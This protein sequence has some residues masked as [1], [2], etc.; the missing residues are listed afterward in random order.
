MVRGHRWQ[1]LSV[2]AA[3][4]ALAGCTGR[5]AAPAGSDAAAPAA[6]GSQAGSQPAPASAEPITVR[7]GHNRAWSNPALILGLAQDRFKQAGINVV[8][9]EFTNPADIVQAI[10]TGDLDAGATPGTTLFTAAQKGVKA[11]AVAL[12][13]GNNNPP[14]AYTVRADSGIN[15]PTDLHGKKAGVNNYGGNYDI[16]LRYW[17]A[18]YGL[19]PKNDLEILVI[20]V[21]SI[22][23]SLVNRQ[24]DVGPLASL[25]SAKAKQ[26]Y[27]ND[28]KILF[29]YDDV[30]QDG[31]G[32]SHNNG[33][34]LAF[35][36]AFVQRNRAGAVRFLTAY[37]RS[38]QAM[39]AD[40]QKALNDWADAVGNDS[41][42]QLPAPPTIPDDGK[43][44]TEALQFDADQGLRFGYLERPVDVRTVIDN[45]LIEEAANQLR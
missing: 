9:T 41:L 45:S 7:L 33:L 30:M 29:T 36:D 18:K 15:S 8:E 2:A 28:L 42:R 25:D 40:P 35:G 13:Q 1:L 26:Q 4:V 34:V 11:K 14:V 10:A 39:N 17:L 16:Y 44:Y 23:P 32:S 21:P 31:V 12:L 22:L 24:L 43:V 6:T 38:V 19:D 20:P 5:T 37:L 3:L 27:G